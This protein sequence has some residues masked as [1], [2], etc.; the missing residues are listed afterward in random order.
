M[1]FTYLFL[2]FFIWGMLLGI[3]TANYTARKGVIATVNAFS[4]FLILNCLPISDPWMSHMR[5]YS[6]AWACGLTC[7]WAYSEMKR[8]HS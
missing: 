6:F 1:L 3:P 8:Q 5:Y 4:P 2:A 7:Y